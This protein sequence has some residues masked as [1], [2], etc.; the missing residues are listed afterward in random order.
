M[1]VL[2]AVDIHGDVVPDSLGVAHLAENPA[3]GRRNALDGGEGAVHVPL[4]V[5][6]DIALGIRIAGRNLPVLLQL[7]DPLGSRGEAA[8][9]VGS[10]NH[11]GLS[12]LGL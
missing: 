8:L 12:D 2:I 7:F 4:L 9:S 10:R 1:H 5:H 6:G 3:V 11:I